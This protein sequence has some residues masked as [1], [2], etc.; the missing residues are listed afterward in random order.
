M[1]PEAAIPHRRTS[2]HEDHELLILE[3]RPELADRLA[4]IAASHQQADAE[5]ERAASSES[6]LQERRAS[7]VLQL[8]N[9]IRTYF[10][11]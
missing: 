3:S 5:R 7:F 10:K 9:R 4:E 8:A 6:E 2:G 1:D 11:L